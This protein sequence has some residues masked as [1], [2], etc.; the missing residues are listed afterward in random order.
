MGKAKR[1]L[2]L[3]AL[4][5][6][7]SWLPLGCES[8]ST[9]II[10][11]VAEQGQLQ[12]N[13]IGVSSS[14]AAY[15]LR[16]AIIVVQ[17]PSSTIF[18]D[19]DQDPSSTS[20]SATVPVGFYTAFLQEG[21]VLERL[22]DVGGKPQSLPATLISPNPVG[23][24]VALGGNTRVPLSFSV[25]GD[26]LDVGS[27]DI[28]LDVQEASSPAAVCS[29]DADCGAGQ[30]CCLGGFLG[31][32]QQ[33][34]PGQG[35]ALPDL[36]VSADAAQQS[37][38]I[39][40]QS[41]PPSSC[42]LQEGCVD[43]PGVRRLLSFATQ[44]A[45]IGGSDIVLG[46]PTTTPGFEFA[47][48]HGHFHFEGYADYQLLDGTGAVA[49][50]GHKQAFCLLDSEPVGIPGAPTT[51]RFHCGFQG[52]QRGWSDVYGAGL[53]CQWVDITDVPEGDY[54]L[55]IRI[56]PERVIQEADYTNNTADIPVHIGAPAVLDPL[57]QC[58]QFEGGVF[59]DCGWAFADKERG[60]SC[61]PGEQILLGCGGCT[62]GGVC[63]GDPVL[64]VCEGTEACLSFNALA[65]ADDSCSAC[66]ETAFTC[67]PSG[68]YSVLTGSFSAGQPFACQPTAVT[69]APIGLLEPCTLF[70]PQRDC[71][72]T[73]NPAFSEGGCVPGQQ[74]TLGCGGCTTGGTCE[75][76]TMLRVCAGSQ[77]CFA[78]EALSINDDA[79]SLCSQV[80]F[81][82]PS[83]GVFTVLTGAYDNGPFV[84]EPAGA[85]PAPSADA[86]AF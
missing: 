47:S 53:D 85:A 77:P 29:T 61:Q 35:C 12:L 62:T 82:C 43:G 55:R 36:T 37:M 32:C 74:V 75:G 48:C 13:L 67:P 6:I 63:Q 18:L 50:T 66:P 10:D 86:G 39:G 80:S 7:G 59:R 8:G 41:F 65:L 73:V 24:S 2:T 58:T 71:G 54:T 46:D 51:P 68:V 25:D 78:R 49:A 15:R 20:L 27:F 69:Q 16:Q 72:W 14:G 38:N 22:S 31:T 9:T 52:I 83:D 60:L 81:T 76:D 34:S 17:G 3:V 26:T 19:S 42:A 1:I 28:V 64:R 45:N 44:T 57:A 21:W 4:A 56:N 5:G 33:L 79:C 23:F 40:F 11:G 70:G 30:T 84:C